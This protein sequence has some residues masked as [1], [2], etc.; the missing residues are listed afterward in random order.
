M[1]VLWTSTMTTA[2]ELR[3]QLA[4]LLDWDNAH[5][6]FDDAVRDFPA[7]LRG[8]R[9]PGGPH[10]GW[11]LLE[12][13]RIALWDILE[14][15]RDAAHVSPEFPSGYWPASAAP[16]SDAAWDESAEA[17]RKHLREFAELV[18]DESADLLARIPHGTGQTLLREVLLA[19]DHNAY[20]VGQLVMVRK[21]VGG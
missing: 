2:N 21:V 1:T 19:A 12:H 4:Q 3:N 13:L 9:P 8:V 18:S 17:Y 16:P 7:E 11:E 5:L 14:F 15:S 10:S 6:R 20:H